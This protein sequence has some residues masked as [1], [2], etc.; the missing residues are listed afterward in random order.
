MN[1]GGAW[2]ML[3]FCEHCEDIVEVEEKEVQKQ[4]TIKGMDI[5]YM[6]KEGYCKECGSILFVP[7]IH[8]YNLKKINEA[9]RHAANLITV[10]EI[11]DIMQLY[12]IGKRPLSSVLGW[13]EQT[14]SRYLDGEIPSKQYSDQLKR[15]GG[16][17]SYMQ[18]LLEENK[19]KITE[20]AYKKSIQAITD[21]KKEYLPRSE[22]KIDCVVQYILSKAEEITP[23]ALQKLLYYSQGFSIAINRNYLFE[24]DCEAWIHGPVYRNIYD[25]YKSFGYNPIEENLIITSNFNL[26]SEE[27][28]MLLDS[29]I[30]NFGCYSG[31]MLERMTHVETPWHEARKGLDED[32]V[33][34]NI[35]E[36]ETMK[37]YFNEIRDKHHMVNITDIEDYSKDIFQK[38]H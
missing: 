3:P 34:N 21:I 17:P 25:K 16:N 27:E 20:H 37:K 10:D 1:E 15:V 12:N 14:I 32:A 24:E 6:G 23:L 28:Q 18:R 2:N 8:D 35:I 33:S 36:K 7:E 5:T 29:V 4:K 31:K 19:N 30:N 22:S 13:G 11:N 9:Y 26:L 38:I